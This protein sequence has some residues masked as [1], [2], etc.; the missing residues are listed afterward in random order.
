MD[1]SLKNV[2][3][4]IVTELPWEKLASPLYHS[5]CRRSAEDS[6]DY[7]SFKARP[8]ADRP[9]NHEGYFEPVTAL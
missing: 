7:T 3:K 6:C 1:I 4:L 9:K 8:I 2:T 5:M